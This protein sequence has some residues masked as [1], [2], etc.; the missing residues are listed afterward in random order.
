MGEAAE[1]RE[2]RPAMAA[3]RHLHAVEDISGEPP[4]RANAEPV[5]YFD[6]TQMHRRIA[7]VVGV[8]MVVITALLWHENRRSNDIAE[9]EYRLKLDSKAHRE[10]VVSVLASGYRRLSERQDRLLQERRR[11][12]NRASLALFMACTCDEPTQRAY[13]WRKYRQL[14]RRKAT[15]RG[16]L[17]DVS[18][19]LASIRDQART[20]G[21]RVKRLRRVVT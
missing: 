15:V 6:E 8:A 7:S 17:S 18:Q 5:R 11:L 21:I 14:S 13:W 9:A 2:P 19:R 20:A 4:S 1:R 10:D 16:Q 3:G 12:S